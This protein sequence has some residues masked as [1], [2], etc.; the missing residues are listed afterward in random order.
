VI[1]KIATEAASGPGKWDEK[2]Y[3]GH[4]DPWESPNEGSR[5]AKALLK[6]PPELVL[7]KPEVKSPERF[8]GLPNR[9]TYFPSR[10]VILGNLTWHGSVGYVANIEI[11]I[12][13]AHNVHRL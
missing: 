13:P 9:I 1:I 8:E 6:Y 3:D 10:G 2:N 4:S 12:T 11:V 7:F 5:I